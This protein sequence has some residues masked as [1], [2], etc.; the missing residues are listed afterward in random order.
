MINDAVPDDKLESVPPRIC[1][2]IATFD[3][4]STLTILLKRVDAYLEGLSEELWLGALATESAAVGLLIAR[5]ESGSREMPAHSFLPAVKE[6]V[7]E[8]LRGNFAPQKY[9]G[10]WDVVISSLKPN[11]LRK[12]AAEIVKEF[13]RT[14]ISTEGAAAVLASY[15]PL[16][17]AFPLADFPNA[18]IDSFITVLVRSGGPAAVDFIQVRAS[19]IRSCLKKADVQVAQ[20]FV[21]LV[22]GLARSSDEANR[23]WG[24][25]V[26]ELLQVALPTEEDDRDS[27]G[28]S[29][30]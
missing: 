24:Q 30:K 14:S 13:E 5:R 9:A 10:Q 25:K 21:E 8:A 18:A 23:E 4:K 20:T 6:N 22:S 16:A 17:K 11:S 3:G 1:S 26:A 12:L 29:E 19:D 7:L 15:G 2:D 28:D 27:E